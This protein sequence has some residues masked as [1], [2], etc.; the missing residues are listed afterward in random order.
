MDPRLKEYYEKI[1]EE[2]EKFEIVENCTKGS[3]FYIQK[4]RPFFVKGGRY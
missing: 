2:I 4:V 3:R 1:A